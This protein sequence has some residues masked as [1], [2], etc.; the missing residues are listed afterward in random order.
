MKNNKILFILIP[1]SL[2]IITILLGIKVNQ[3]LCDDILGN[4]ISIFYLFVVLNIIHFSYFFYIFYLRLKKRA[5]TIMVFAS[6][7]TMVV[8]LILFVSYQFITMGRARA[9]NLGPDPFVPSSNITSHR[10]V[11]FW[12]I[13]F[14][15]TDKMYS[16]KYREDKIAKMQKT[17]QGS[18]IGHIGTDLQGW[19]DEK[20][21]TAFG[22]PAKTIQVDE[23]LE[24]WIYHPWTN[25]PDW[26]MPVY[27]QNGVLLKIGD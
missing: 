27:V 9:L 17:R 15:I 21:V 25:H 20:I 24:K 12:S 14:W 16:E 4:T 1:V 5:K 23:S 3:N 10:R 2:W 18:L 26:E 7:P 6:L 13:D 8:Y 19:T 11:P 22:K